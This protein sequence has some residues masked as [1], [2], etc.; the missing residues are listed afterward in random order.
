MLI[1][2]IARAQ[3][4]AVEEAAIDRD[5]AAQVDAILL[6]AEPHFLRFA[7]G[8]ERIAYRHA[9]EI[10]AMGKGHAQIA[11]IVDIG[12]AAG[13]FPDA[14]RAVGQLAFE[15]RKVGNLRV[16]A[17][18]RLRAQRGRQDIAAGVE[19]AGLAIGAVQ[20]NH[21]LVGQRH[22]DFARARAFIGGAT[23]GADRVDMDR[24]V[25]HAARDAAV[26]HI[27]DA[28]DRRRSVEQR[29]GAAQDFDAIGGQRIDRNGMVDRCVRHVEAADPVGQDAH[30][31]ALE[32]AQDGARR[33]GAK[34]C[35][36][37]AGLPR[38]RFADAGAQFAGQLFPGQHAG[39]RQY[40][41]LTARDQR[42]D[43]DVGALVMIAA[44]LRRIG[45][46]RALGKAGDGKA[47]Q[48]ES[49]T[50]AQHRKAGHAG[51]TL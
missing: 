33:A 19:I 22:F 10:V 2:G 18:R 17:R 43:D 40:V 13:H 41:A 24:F 25:G 28:A 31:L 37:H 11:A 38:Q 26:D 20:M 14:P 23:I 42:S 45:R 44:I 4:D 49:A 15:V 51:S 29:R 9:I 12:R 46:W 34:G 48:R 27:D 47:Q 32:T 8:V 35:R 36:R 6:H 7:I 39:A 16:S 21:E 1:I 5:L 3:A 50:G 30:A